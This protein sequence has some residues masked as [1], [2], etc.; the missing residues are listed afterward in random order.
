MTVWYRENNL[1][2]SP[3]KMEV[4]IVL[5]KKSMFMLPLH[6]GRDCVERVADV[7]FLVVHIEEDPTWSV[8]T[9]ELLKKPS[10]DCTS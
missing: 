6:I 2:F 4:I 5:I 9:S 8:N 10:R 1:L 7:H 3:S